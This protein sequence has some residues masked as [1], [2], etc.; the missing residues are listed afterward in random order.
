M[1][2]FTTI[3]DITKPLDTSGW[4]PAHRNKGQS[5]KENKLTKKVLENMEIEVDDKIAEKCMVDDAPD[6]KN[7]EKWTTVTKKK[8]NKA[9]NNEAIVSTMKKTKV[10]FT[11]RVPKDI[12][13]FS[14][15]TIHLDTLHAIHKYDESMIV[16]NQAGDTKVN[17]EAPMS[18]KQ[19]KDFFK[20]VEKQI[21]RGP[22]QISISHEIFM[23]CKASDCKEAIFPH[24]IKN[25]TFLY[26]NPKPGLEH[27]TAI[28]VL[29]GPNPDFTWRDDLANLLI[30]TIKSEIN[31]EEKSILGTTSENQ[32]KIIL[33]LNTQ[34]IGHSVPTTTTS[35]ALEIRVPT[36]TERLYTHIL[37]R[38]YE[39]AEE[40]ELLIP[41][42][43]GKFFPY[44]MK[45]KKQR[46]LTFSCDNRT[47]KW[48]ALG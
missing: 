25:K 45:S 7:D 33:S 28:S 22:G 46:F 2:S 15:A 48:Q 26:F 6:T 20:P 24:L 41:D 44:N 36:G 9:E 19:Y 21:G 39:K 37:E 31:E 38:L 1:A 43:L 42:K 34:K 23:T 17:I 18:E 35:V 4:F 3:T 32:P 14:P 27:F 40:S 47:R 16:F 29:F 11:I 8:G 10:T 30:E 12:S 5:T 13:N